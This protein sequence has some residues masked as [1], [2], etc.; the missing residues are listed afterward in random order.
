ML[1]G[2]GRGYFQGAGFKGR[3]ADCSMQ[4]TPMDA[5]PSF[6]FAGYSVS[7]YN[8]QYNLVIEHQGFMQGVVVGALA[9]LEKPLTQR[10]HSILSVYSR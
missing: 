8:I 7:L 9:P 2:P 3:E 10:M 4:T 6:G 1:G 5:L